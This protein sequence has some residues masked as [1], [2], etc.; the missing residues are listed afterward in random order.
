LALLGKG[1]LKL[2]GHSGHRSGSLGTRTRQLRGELGF[3][4]F[5]P[6]QDS[7]CL[8]AS[9]V[10]LGAHSREGSCGLLDS[11][12]HGER[13]LEGSLAGFSGFHGGSGGSLGSQGGS[14]V[15]DLV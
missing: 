10:S 2:A 12:L 9:F 3:D 7:G 15:L 1:D 8:T 5:S 11:R 14:V 6:N 4:S 13:L